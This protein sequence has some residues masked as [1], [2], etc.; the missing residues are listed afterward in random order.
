[1]FQS[2]LIYSGTIISEARSVAE[3]VDQSV[4]VCGRGLG[5]GPLT[6]LG[7]QN[8]PANLLGAAVQALPPPDVMSGGWLLR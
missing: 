2:L 1:M 8:L 5:L 3:E 7:P 6:P 4:T